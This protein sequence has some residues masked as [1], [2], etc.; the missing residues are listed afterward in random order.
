MAK[1]NRNFVERTLSE[2]NKNTKGSKKQS[3][4]VSDPSQRISRGQQRYNLVSDIKKS[5]DSYESQVAEEGEKAEKRSMWSTIGGVLG[6]AAGIAAA[7]V[8]LAGAGLATAGAI[9]TGLVTAG[10]TAA[11]TGIGAGA[12]LAG[13][14][15]TGAKRKDIKVDKFFNKKAQEATDTFKDYD[16]E[17][18]KSVYKQMAVSGAMAGLQASGAFK[19]AGEAVKKGLGM[20]TGVET[21]AVLDPNLITASDI[22]GTGEGLAHVTSKGAASPSQLAEGS[23]VGVKYTGPDIYASPSGTS[24]ASIPDRTIPF[25]PTSDRNLYQLV[26]E[27]AIGQSIN[28]GVNS[29]LSDNRQNKNQNQQ[30]GVIQVPKY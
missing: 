20:G 16:K 18:N 30:L 13:A 17:I 29:L 7:P 1:R 2:V 9:T 22:G 12:G 19:A 6:A 4:K 10:A 24:V 25:G 23:T 28:Y 3:K 21:G 8:L 15:E 27:Q 11:G 5:Q 14:K 26:K